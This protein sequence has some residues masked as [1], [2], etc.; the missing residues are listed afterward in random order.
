MSYAPYLATMRMAISKAMDSNDPDTKVG[1][2]I[3]SEKHSPPQF[4]ASG[5]NIV[6]LPFSTREEK[7]EAAAH[8]EKMAIHAAREVGRTNLVDTTIVITRMPCSG[9]M[10]DIWLSGCKRV[11]FLNRDENRTDSKWALSFAR[12]REIAAKFHIELIAM[13]KEV[14]YESDAA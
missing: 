5:C 10:T 14:V 2:V 13:P 6:L 1:A 4:I 11:V 9:C 7:L 3:V 8:A 12:A